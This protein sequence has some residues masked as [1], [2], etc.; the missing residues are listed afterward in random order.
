MLCMIWALLLIYFSSLTQ[1]SGF[2]KGPD[3][4]NPSAKCMVAS[5]SSYRI[6]PRSGKG[7]LIPKCHFQNLY[8]SIYTQEAFSAM[9]AL[10]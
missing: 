6:G 3:K 9:V 10:L 5:V 8:F 2:K 1:N 7:H 4:T